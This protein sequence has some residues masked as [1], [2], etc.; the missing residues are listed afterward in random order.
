MAKH[1]YYTAPT[2]VSDISEADFWG[3]LRVIKGRPGSEHLRRAIQLGKSARKS[4]AYSALAEYHRCALSEEIAA[5]RFK[6]EKKRAETDASK[7]QDLRICL[8]DM[9]KNKINIWHSH[10]FD[11]GKKIDWGVHKGGGDSLYGFHYLAWL[12]PAIQETILSGDTIIHTWLQKTLQSYFDARSHIPVH[13]NFPDRGLSSNPVYYILGCGNKALRLPSAYLALLS[14]GTVEPSTVESVMKLLIGFTRAITILQRESV[15]WGGNSAIVA[16]GALF[17]LGVNF[18]EFNKSSTW[19]RESEEWLLQLLD[20]DYFEDGGYGERVWGYG[21]FSFT[22]LIA[23]W[24]TA[25]KNG[26]FPNHDKEITRRLR[27]AFQWYAKTL[28]PKYLMPSAGD[29]GLDTNCGQATMTLGSRVFPKGTNA[30]FGVDREKSYLLKPSG[31]AIM[32]NGD[33]AD[34]GYANIS[35]GK[36]AG[37]HSHYDLLSLNFWSHGQPLIE[38]IGRWGQYENELDILFRAPESHNL[39]LLDGW[40]YDCRAE[41][42][43]DVR[44]YSTPE[45]DYFSAYH[46]AY[47]YYG[48]RH[49]GPGSLNIQDALIRRT[50]VFVKDSGYLLVMDAAYDESDGR[51]IKRAVSQLWHSPFPFKQIGP[52]LVRTE[53][54]TACLLAFAR[55]ESVRRLDITTAFSGAEVTSP[56]PYPDRYSL[57]ARRWQSVYEPPRPGFATVLY[58]FKGKVPNIAIKAIEMENGE[59]FRVEAFEV[60]TPHSTD[61][62]I[63]NPEKR[64]GVKDS[65][66]SSISGHGVVVLGN[67][68]GY[69]TIP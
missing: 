7:I 51:A 46:R 45:I 10:I 34:S 67:K 60:T 12:E 53:G 9:V 24:E 6:A 58:P 65:K 57:R 28:G 2:E 66:G 39:F 56:I 59:P 69:V 49:E 3:G 55:P 1:I 63:L 62:I 37:W 35:F 13:P 61:L 4:E 54:T 31:F 42:A 26:G 64:S 25:Q 68:R 18:S 16:S 33:S 21:Y 41:A 11:F 40:M 5:A 44:W 14:S 52:G 30:N 22:G 43:H 17:Q 47:R 27:R 29:C 23:A 48:F 36:F 20:D 32:R 19:V 38:E 15:K 8:A 50:V